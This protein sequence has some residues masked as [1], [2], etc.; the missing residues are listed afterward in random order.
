M[1]QTLS[2]FN[3]SLID[4][5]IILLTL[6]TGIATAIWFPHATAQFK[7]HYRATPL[8]IIH[9]ILLPLVYFGIG[10]FVA[11]SI[12]QIFKLSFPRSKALR[13]LFLAFSFAAVLI[14]AIL[15]LR[16]Y[17]GFSLGMSINKHVMWFFVEHQELFSLFGILVFF[18]SHRQIYF[19]SQ[20]E[21]DE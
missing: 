8:I 19:S 14:C 20:K 13:A 3:L 7:V 15:Y 2:K 6:A 16:F 21:N 10:Y 11:L 1:K 9:A 17:C 18:G 4:A 12:R 5:I